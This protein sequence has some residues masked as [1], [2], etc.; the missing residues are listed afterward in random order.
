MECFQQLVTRNGMSLLIAF[1][2]FFHLFSSISDFAVQLVA[3]VV[4][5]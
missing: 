3:L 5:K 2:H 1:S 4:Y